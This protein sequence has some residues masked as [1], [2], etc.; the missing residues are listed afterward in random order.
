MAYIIWFHAQN[1]A[2]SYLARQTQQDQRQA[3]GHCLVMVR[4]RQSGYRLDGAWQASLGRRLCYILARPKLRSRQGP[5]TLRRSSFVASLPP[6][7]KQTS[8]SHG[9][10]RRARLSRCGRGAGGLVAGCR[11]PACRFEGRVIDRLKCRFSRVRR[12]IGVSPMGGGFR[13]GSDFRTLAALLW[14]CRLLLSV[15]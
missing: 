11:A 10:R 9:R 7:M 14:Y 3:H 6:G 15:C 13:T 1:L 12:Y 4:I 2:D 8:I 5:R